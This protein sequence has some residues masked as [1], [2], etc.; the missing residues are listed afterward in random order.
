MQNDLQAAN[1]FSLQNTQRKKNEIN[2]FFHII[3]EMFLGPEVNVLNSQIAQSGGKEVTSTDKVAT[4]EKNR[5]QR[6]ILAV[7][8]KSNAIYKFKSN[9]TPAKNIP[10]HIFICLFIINIVRLRVRT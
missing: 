2:N 6:P 5:C 8:S 10:S 3:V 1:K 9:W 7:L 4:K